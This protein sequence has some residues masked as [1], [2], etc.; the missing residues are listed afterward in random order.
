MD[1]LET[2][3]LGFA[4]GALTLGVTALLMYKKAIPPDLIYHSGIEPESEIG[5]CREEKAQYAY[6]VYSQI[7]Q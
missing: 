2:F 5:K 6:P 4:T 3:M 7:E 1:K